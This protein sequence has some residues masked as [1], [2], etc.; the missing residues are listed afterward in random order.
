MNAH[1]APRRVLSFNT[2]IGI[3]LCFSWARAVRLFSGQH[4]D[5][6]LFDEIGEFSACRHR[7]VAQSSSRIFPVCCRIP[8][9]ASFVPPHSHTHVTPASGRQLRQ[10]AESTQAGEGTFNVVASSAERFAMRTGCHDYTNSPALAPHRESR[11][12]WAYFPI[13]DAVASRTARRALRRMI[14]ESYD[15]AYSSA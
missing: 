8:V 14:A 5:A 6:G 2:S 12:W 15:N 9:A 13:I 10:A 7:S 3:G 1:A 11:T 4:G